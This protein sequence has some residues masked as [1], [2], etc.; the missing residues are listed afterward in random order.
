MNPKSY[1]RSE[2]HQVTNDYSIQDDDLPSEMVQEQEEFMV[3]R[4]PMRTWWEAEN[5]S[6]NFSPHSY[7]N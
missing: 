6:H 7:S 1:K 3:K 2:F 5:S 4:L